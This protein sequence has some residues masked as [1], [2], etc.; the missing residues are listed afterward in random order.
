MDDADEA[1]DKQQDRHYPVECTYA[2]KAACHNKGEE[3]SKGSNNKDCRKAIHEASY[4]GAW[5]K[6]ENH[7]ENGTAD[8]G[9]GKG[10]TPKRLLTF[11]DDS[12]FLVSS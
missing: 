8:A 12:W 1:D 11:D 10:R 6:H 2:G 9:N 4:K 5:H 3:L 7:T